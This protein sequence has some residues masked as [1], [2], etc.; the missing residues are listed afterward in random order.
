MGELI[1]LSAYRENR[2]AL[3]LRKQNGNIA[4]SIDPVGKKALPRL[5][6]PPL[7]EVFVRNLHLR[8]TDPYALDLFILELLA[9]PMLPKLD[10]DANGTVLNADYRLQTLGP[11]K[12]AFKMALTYA[13]LHMEKSCGTS[14]N[15]LESVKKF[16][17]LDLYA[18]AI[19][20][21]YSIAWQLDCGEELVIDAISMAKR[22][23]K[24]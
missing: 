24:K 4:V 3:T 1:D 11:D 5:E 6:L 8:V 16:P 9:D 2:R 14:M 7:G 15:R 21:M 19:L 10:L 23:A 12:S 17:K 13:R 18:R 20:G 22:H